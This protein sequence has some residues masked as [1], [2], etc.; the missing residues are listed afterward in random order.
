MNPYRVVFVAFMSCM[1]KCMHLIKLT[2]VFTISVKIIHIFYWIKD[3]KKFFFG[4]AIIMYVVIMVIN[5]L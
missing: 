5:E 4:M 3:L 1:H 2:F